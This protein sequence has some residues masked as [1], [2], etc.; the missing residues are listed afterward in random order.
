MRIRDHIVTGIASARL[1]SPYPR[2]DHDPA[3][4]YRGGGRAGATITASFRAVADA[5]TMLAESPSDRHEAVSSTG[6]RKWVRKVSVAE[7]PTV[8]PSTIE[9]QQTAAGLSLGTRSSIVTAHTSQ[10]RSR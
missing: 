8:V 5:A 7:A 10:T 2:R 6:R 1:G 9:G 3:D 4:A